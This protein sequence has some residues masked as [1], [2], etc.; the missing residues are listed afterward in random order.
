MAKRKIAPQADRA[1]L[2]AMIADRIIS[3]MVE[4]GRSLV[5][6][7]GDE[8]MPSRRTVYRWLSENADFAAQV[9]K[10]R[11]AAA[12]HAVWK[13]DQVV[14]DTKPETAN[15]DRIKLVHLHWKASRMAPSKYSEKRIN[16]LT[17]K[18]GG[19]VQTEERPTVLDVAAMSAE[20]RAKLRALL[21]AAK[22]RSEG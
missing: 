8:G 19:P 15:A 12:D 5:E 16:E 18:D 9:E 10:A 14:R 13:A 1:G 22:K 4:N 7:C 2:T 21:L 17:G 3:E 11:E 20:E 6:I